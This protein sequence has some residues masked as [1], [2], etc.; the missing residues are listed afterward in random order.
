MQKL[1]NNY[2]VLPMHTK[3]KISDAKRIAK[4]VN[5]ILRDK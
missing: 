4:T 3:M 2:L 5:Y 1:Q